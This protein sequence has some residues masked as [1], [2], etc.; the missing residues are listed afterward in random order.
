[1]ND[2]ASSR[3][4]LPPTDDV[5]R[6]QQQFNA[7]MDRY[8]R[9]PVYRLIGKVTSIVIVSFQAYFLIMVMN[10]PLAASGHLVAF[11]AAFV[12]A[13]FVNGF[14]H[15]VMDNTAGYDSAVGPLIAAFHLHHKTPAYRRSFLPWVYV[16]E[17]GAK[18]WLACVYA[19]VAL[20]HTFFSLPP[21]PL[22]LFAYFGI[23][24]S[25]AEVSHYLCHVH[26]GPFARLLAKTGLLLSPRH[27]GKHHIA[28][29][30]HY[31]FLNGMTNPLLDLIA[32]RFFAGYK[33]NTDL[34]HAAYTGK[35]TANR[36]S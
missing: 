5:A 3:P 29:N 24:S 33:Q 13:D 4:A 30:V 1:M 6:K 21:F 15:L 28:D 23:L 9:R 32:R 16:N 25:V 22:A 18:I 34:H 8:E 2:P 12:L 35:G 20:F 36:A 19:L 17:S 26:R 14:V 27:H 31:A 7:A 11:L 10:R